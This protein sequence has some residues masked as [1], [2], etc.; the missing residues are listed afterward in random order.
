MPLPYYDPRPIG[1]PP[2]GRE[3]STVGGTRAFGRGRRHGN[4][5]GWGH[6][7]P[8]D[9]PP[10]DQLDAI[11]REHDAAYAPDRYTYAERCAADARLV[12]RIDRWIEGAPPETPEDI[13][14]A[15]RGMR[16]AMALGHTLSCG[17]LG[18]D[19]TGAPDIPPHPAE[20]GAAA[21]LALPGL[22][23]GLANDQDEAER[24]M[25]AECA[26]WDRFHC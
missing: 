24:I 3:R 7:S 20:R 21:Q 4:Y 6:T 18:L 13:R 25:L 14:G 17:T 2:H 12:N 9:T 26:A 23:N 5:C 10:V 11:C 19:E 8:L 1:A 16:K 15:A 22:A